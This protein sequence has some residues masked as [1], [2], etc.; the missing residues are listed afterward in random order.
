M[1]LW[2]NRCPSYAPQWQSVLPR[3]PINN[4]WPYGAWIHTIHSEHEYSSPGW[5]VPH[6][7]CH[8]IISLHHLS[9]SLTL[10]A[11]ILEDM[12]SSASNPHRTHSQTRIH[13]VQHHL[14]VLEQHLIIIFW[15]SYWLY[16]LS[17]ALSQL[18]PW[19]LPSLTCLLL[20][21]LSHQL[22]LL[23][24]LIMVAILQLL[25]IPT[26]PLSPLFPPLHPLPL[27][28]TQML[29]LL[30]LPLS[31]LPLLVLLCPMLKLY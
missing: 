2:V 20:R 13:L 31:H 30:F 1:L 3:N 16:H 9:P 21:T 19:D 23:P 18:P 10:P 15:L 5:H 28:W 12:H 14:L 25:L 17:S 22:V 6:L 24:Q 7:T 11:D 4:S 26:L 29:L 8:L 27:P